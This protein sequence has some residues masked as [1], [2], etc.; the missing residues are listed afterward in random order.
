[1]GDKVSLLPTSQEA[2]MVRRVRVRIRTRARTRVRVRVR[3][4]VRA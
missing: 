1:V 3:V 4:R 2:A